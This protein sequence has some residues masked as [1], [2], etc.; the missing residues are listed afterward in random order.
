MAA[1]LAVAARSGAQFQPVRPLSVMGPSSAGSGLAASVLAGSSRSRSAPAAAPM[2]APSASTTAIAERRKVLMGIILPHPREGFLKIALALAFFWSAIGAAAPARADELVVGA[3]RDQDGAVVAGAAVTALDASGAVLA[4]DR[5]AKDGTFALTAPSRPAAVLIVA[6]D[7]E[8]QRVSVPA[9][10]SPVAAIVRRH[11][12]ADLVPSVADVAALPAGSPSEVASVVPYRVTFP[13]VVSERWLAGGNG[14]VTVEGLPFYRRGDGADATALIPSHAFGALDVRDPLQGLWYGDRAG[15][16]LVDLRLF[17]RSD[18]ARATT[19][20]AFLAAGRTPAVLA[21]SSWDPDGTRRLVAARAS[22]A[23]GPVSASFVV[24]AG[25][26]PGAHFAGAGAELHAATR[27]LDLGAHLAVTGDDGSTAAL[28]DA[29]S[30]QDVALDVSGRGPNALAV[31]ARWR[32]ERGA[33]GIADAD[34]QDAALV[35]GT[36]RGNALRAT[37]AL[38]LAYGSEHAYELGT[39]TGFSLLPSLSL[40]APLG[41]S[42]TLHAGTGVSTLGTFGYALG[43]ASLGEA[44]IAF[45]DH[46]RVR[47]ELLAYAEGTSAPATVNRGL[48]AALGWEIAPRLSLR[49]WS[50]RDVDSVDLT[51]AAYPGGPGQ[52]SSVGE[53]FD[54]DVAW[55]TWDGPARFDLLLRANALEGSVRVPVGGRYALTLGSFVRRD[56]TRAFSLGLVAR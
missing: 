8:P 40:D 1:V 42:W 21:A 26:A 13:G 51:T 20:D 39:R 49:A 48:A 41:E 22:D 55:L 10:G 11:R 14:V 53:R 17:D 45:S 31:R 35:L 29:G 36:T 56:A 24:L 15:G 44:G 9:D 19:R 52:T 5:S 18:A 37:A 33:L 54:R 4:R 3:L 12:A 30:V 16:G 27:V 50:V 7:A 46:R 47:A 43:R 28:H 32:D 34:H 23:L 6:A 2:H 38:A 25:S